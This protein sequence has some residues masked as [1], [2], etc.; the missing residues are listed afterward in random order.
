[1][2]L[3]FLADSNFKLK[4]SLTRSRTSHL[5]HSRTYLTCTYASFILYY[6]VSC[7]VYLSLFV[8]VPIVCRRCLWNS[9][10]TWCAVMTRFLE[11]FLCDCSMCKISMLN[12][13]SLLIHT[14]KK[15]YKLHSSWILVMMSSIY[16]PSQIFLLYSKRSV[17]TQPLNSLM[18]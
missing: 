9:E 8:L 11:F 7:L 1:M 15:D 17:V 12:G 14:L 16:T 13:L 4:T 2:T 6:L 10:G 3:P 18:I 5:D